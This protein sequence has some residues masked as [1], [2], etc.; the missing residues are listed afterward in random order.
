MASFVHGPS[1]SII[2]DVTQFTPTIGADSDSSLWTGGTTPDN[3]SANGDTIQFL[4]TSPG[5]YPFIYQVIDNFGCTYDTTITLT[6][7]EPFEVEAGPDGVI[8]STPLQLGATIVGSSATC[9]WT[10]Q[11]DDSFGDGWNGAAITVT[12]NGD[13]NTYNCN[14]NQTIE[15]L[16]VQGGDVISLD[17]S[18]GTFEN[19]VSY[20]LFDDQG[21][22]LFQDGPDPAI[23]PVWSGIV[24]C[25]GQGGMTWQWSPTTGLS[26]PTISD[27]TV[28]VSSPTEFFVTA[29]ITGHPDCVATDSVSISLDPGLDPGLDSLVILCATPPSFQLIDLLGG[30]P[31]T[32]GTWTDANGNVVPGTFDPVLDMAG[33]YTYTVVTPLGCI[34]TADLEIQILPASDPTCC[35]VVDAGPD[36][37]ICTLTYGLNASPGNTGVGQWSGPPGYTFANAG[38][39]QSQVTAPGSGPAMLFWTE[40]DGVLCYLIDSVTVTF[41]EPLVATITPTDAICFEACDGTAV[42]TMTGGNGA[43]TYTW[44][45]ALAADTTVA[46]D[47]CAGDYSIT[48]ADE[49]ACSTSTDFS[50][51][52]PE[53]L[54][55]D[56]VSYVEPWCHGGCDGSILVTD[57]AAVEYSFD[58]GATFQTEPLLEAVC[59][60]PY[61]LIIRNAEGCVGTGGVV[62]PEPPAVLAD[63]GHGPIPANVNAPTISFHNLSQNAVSYLWDI[64]GLMSTTD[65]NTEF[66]FTNKE[67]GTYNVCLVATDAH[68]CS[69]TVCH[70]V[71]IDDV[72]FTYV[73]NSFTPDGDGVNEDWGLYANIADIKELQ[74]R[75]FDRWGGVVF[76]ATEPKMRWNGGFKNGG[77]VLPQGVYPYRIVF[78]IISTGG[79]RELTGHVTL[80]K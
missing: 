63:F 76:E 80:I 4:A 22:I 7:N 27:P 73:P 25:G 30:T 61:V 26:D 78:Q 51:G 16:A 5:D 37:L 39:P 24:T 58:G 48:V 53:L 20:V 46:Q 75:V 13:A 35:G 42:V 3:I 15:I 38:D 2:P 17:Y 11:M 36:S 79:V 52:Q 54:T 69:D 44:S 23:G 21:A 71:V 67:P 60:G 55:I 45:D 50:L 64:D 14:G 34:G 29:F 32:G 40:D 43:Y 6:V 56:S 62:V 28:N 72:L 1:T 10:L 49:N 19:E 65:V 57:L 66:T 33:I 41:T 59:T 77:E 8:C 18:S 74:L 68:A 47:I 9:N 31:A 12:I 70:D